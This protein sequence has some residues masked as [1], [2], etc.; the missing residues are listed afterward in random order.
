MMKY[1]RMDAAA[2]SLVMLSEIHRNA[3]IIT[4]DRRFGRQRLP[5]VLPPS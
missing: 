2:A 5:V 4:T 1:Q 3:R